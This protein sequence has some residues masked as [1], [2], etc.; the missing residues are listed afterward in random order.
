MN[1]WIA[2]LPA[3]KVAA[4]IAK[5][6][7][8][9]CEEYHTTDPTFALWMHY[10]DRACRRRVLVSCYDLEDWAYWDAYD[11]GM[12]PVEACISMLSANGY[13]GAYSE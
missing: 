1:P 9:A 11:D 6:G 12:S 2:A 10:L 4:W 8:R 5:N 3:D 13:E 7:E